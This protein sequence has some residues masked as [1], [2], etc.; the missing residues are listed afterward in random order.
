VII[1]DAADGPFLPITAELYWVSTVILWGGDRKPTRPVVVIEAPLGRLTRIVVVTRTTDTTRK[2]VPHQ[3][4][5]EIGLAKPGVFADLR[6]AES[7]LWTPRNARRLGI[8]PQEVFD[9]VM[10]R[11]G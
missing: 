7:S 6:S 11:F 5:P 4:M 1:H 9:D 10:R 3:A 2:G 8:L